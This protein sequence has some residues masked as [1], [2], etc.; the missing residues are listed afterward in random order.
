MSGKCE[1]CLFTRNYLFLVKIW[2]D[3]RKKTVHSLVARNSWFQ[4]GD[5]RDDPFH[6]HGAESRMIK[7]AY[8]LLVFL[9]I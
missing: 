8:D 9:V 1:F 2:L 4:T 7:R 6:D 3:P 5:R